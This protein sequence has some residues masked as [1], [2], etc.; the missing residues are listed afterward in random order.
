MCAIFC[1][2]LVKEYMSKASVGSGPRP[3]D[4][5]SVGFASFVSVDSSSSSRLTTSPSLVVL[6]EKTSS[7]PLTRRQKKLAQT[8]SLDLPDPPDPDPDPLPPDPDPNSIGPVSPD[9]SGAGPGG[10]SSSSAGDIDVHDLTLSFVDPSLEISSGAGSPKD[11]VNSSY[12]IVETIKEVRQE[13]ETA[14]TSILELS[15]SETVDVNKTLPSEVAFSFDEVDSKIIDYLDLLFRSDRSSELS[16][17][18]KDTWSDFRSRPCKQTLFLRTCLIFEVL[19]PDKS[20]V[21]KRPREAVCPSVRADL[22][23]RV[24]R[25]IEFAR[26][27]RLFT[28]NPSRFSDSLFSPTNL[29]QDSNPFNSDFQSFWETVMTIP[30]DAGRSPQFANSPINEE[31]NSKLMSPITSDE[32]GKCFPRKGSAPGPDLASVGELRRISN[33]ELAKFFNIFLLC[34]QL[35]DR[36]SRART[37]FL[38]KKRDAKEPGDF[39]PISLT[40]I[41]AR[42]FSK[43]LARRLAPTVRLDPEQRG[44]IPSDGIAQNTFL[45]DFVLRHSK[46]K[47]KRTFVASLDLRKAFDSVSHEAVFSALKA[48]AVDHRFVELIQSIYSKSS[49]SFAPFPGH[50]FSP[51]CGVKQGDPLSSILFNLVVDQLIKKL[52]GPVG[53][54]IDGPTLSVSAYADDI[55]LFASSAVG[56]QHLLNEAAEFLEKCNLFVNCSKSFTISILADAKTK[57]TKVDSATPFYI[58]SDSLRIL[59]T[60]DSF[61]YLGV[62]FS[63]KGLLAE[64]CCPTLK[65]YLTK[66]KSAPLKPQQRLWIL[67]NTL[68]PKL[69]HLLVLSSVTAGKLAKLDSV[70]RA[71][72]RGA[73]FLPNDCPNSFIHASVADGG[74]GVP[75]FR[76]SVPLWRRSRL[77]GLGAVMSG[78]SLSGTA[79]GYLQRLSDRVISIQISDNPNAYFRQKLYNSVDGA[80][81]ASS[82]K[83]KDQNLWVQSRNKFLSGRDYVNL[84]KTKIACLPTAS[85]CARGRP[86]KD[87][88]CRAGCPRKETLN[89]I[90]QTCPRTHGKRIMRH[91]AVANYV[92]RACENRGYEVVTEPLYRTTIGNRKPDILA[93]KGDK[94]LVIDAQ[95]VGDSVD[96]DRANDRKIHYYRDNLDLDQQIQSKYGTHDVSY[97]G[98]T[99]NIR[100]VWSAKS[101]NDLVN[102]FKIL[103]RTDVPVVSTRVL[104]GTFASFTMFSRSTARATRD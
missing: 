90:P 36:F 43:V 78:G 18:L 42:L 40:P 80:A 39:R 8:K 16:A 89:H 50:K 25:R 3:A 54:D 95:V 77:G 75:S 48:Q 5:D 38:P 28:K 101:A 34:R 44:F 85:R 104:I 1:R 14:N 33:F 35:P 27:Q 6:N 20:N 49:T 62:N 65:D 68:L 10:S 73:L 70:T 7:R 31:L 32:I 11:L 84:L 12:Q 13:L 21:S 23:R 97:L 67:K 17:E 9:L 100:G 98:V 94:V 26:A 59:K 24:R 2:V 88:Y 29:A 71:F 60:C 19:L 103:S 69:F 82:F 76:V 15:R 86:A 63:A 56:L 4:S 81:L 99:L 64:D 61:K 57:K 30:R 41:P 53:L 66:L 74:L 55:L 51:T 37:I 91:E 83:V 92:K 52:K 93:K 96:L 79:G 46:E 72:V 58:K 45:L 47:S 87:K 102:K 22:S